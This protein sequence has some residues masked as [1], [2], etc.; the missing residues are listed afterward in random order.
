[1]LKSLILNRG[2][3]SETTQYTAEKIRPHVLIYQHLLQHLWE[4]SETIS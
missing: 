2:A 4:V 3:N 1:M